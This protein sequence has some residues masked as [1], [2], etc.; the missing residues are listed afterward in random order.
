MPNTRAIYTIYYS[1]KEL[2]SLSDSGAILDSEQ[3]DWMSITKVFP[4]LTISHITY[5]AIDQHIFNGL[6]ST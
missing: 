2:R 3:K 5:I 1:T 6:I 4:I